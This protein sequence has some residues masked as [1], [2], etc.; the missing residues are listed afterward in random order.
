ML[1]GTNTQSLKFE[2]WSNLTLLPLDVTY[3][4]SR[5][6]PDHTIAF[7]TNHILEELRRSPAKSVSQIMQFG[8]ISFDGPMGTARCERGK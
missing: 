7:A 2:Y 4:F 5:Y 1:L 8:H 6:P 3:D